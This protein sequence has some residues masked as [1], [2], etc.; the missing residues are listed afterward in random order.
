MVRADPTLLEQVIVNLT[1]NARDAMPRGGVVTI[2]TANLE[3]DRPYAERHAPMP[4]GRYVLL[5][6]SDTGIGM[7]ATTMAHLFE[8]FF[9]TK[10]PDEGTGLGLA[11]VYGIVKQSHGYISVYSEPD[12]GATFKVYLPCVAAVHE[13]VAVKDASSEGFRGSEVVL[14]VEDD[15]A[16]L[17]PTQRALEGAGYTVLP[18]RS[19]HEAL[20][21]AEAHD[22]PIH[23]LVTDVVMPGMN[24]R[25]V[26]LLL[27]PDRPTTKVLYVSGYPDA[28]IV[29]QGLLPRGLAFLQ[30]PFAPGALARKVREVL[31]VG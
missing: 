17:E 15:E 27:E 6:V 21:L 18:A 9:T 20:H 26:A 12:Q 25:E 30:K 16:V 24:G 10:G 28:S 4:P 11:T 14:L 29:N 7:N 8:P 5:A 2:E 13:T 1:V 23:V 22:G 19:G 31:D 3:I